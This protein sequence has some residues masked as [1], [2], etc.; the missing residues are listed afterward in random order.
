MNDFNELH[1]LYHHG[2]KGQ[3]W[4]VRRFQNDDGTLTEEG[5]ARYGSGSVEEMSDASKKLYKSDRK[6]ALKEAKS[7]RKELS[8]I[9]GK[10]I[11]DRIVKR[12]IGSI[13][14]KDLTTADR[15]TAIGKNIAKGAGVAAG[16]IA[17]MS[18]V[19][20]I[21]LNGVLDKLAKS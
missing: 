21:A 7:E 20:N 12:Q 16:I 10:D 1:A 9:Y 2:I 15:N 11:A 6:N 13:S 3:K 14:A 5:K 19:P 8:K 17:M 4:G 18:A